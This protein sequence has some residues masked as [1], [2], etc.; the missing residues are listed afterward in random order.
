MEKKT[1][2]RLTLEISYI[3]LS[4]AF[5]TVCSYLSFKAGLTTYTLQLAA[6]LICSGLFGWKRAVAAVAIYTLMGLIGI[7]VFAGFTAGPS[8]T[9]GFVIGFLFTAILAGLC[10]YFKEKKT[11]VRIAIY[12]GLM[13]A[14]IAL[15]YAFGTVW[16]LFWMQGKYTLSE[17]IALCVVP[18]LWFDA[19]KLAVAV[20]MV[21]RLRNVVRN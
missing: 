20:L 6:V 9:S 18:Y 16:F 14:G 1:A 2:K 10:P 13:T 21:D 3:A 7:P 15:C 12:V 4:I 8:H 11:V 5:I 19:I 17:A